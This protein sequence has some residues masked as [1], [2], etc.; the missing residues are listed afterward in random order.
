MTYTT[1]ISID[2]AAGGAL[3]HKRI[4]EAYDLL[5]NMALNHYQWSN[6]RGGT[7]KKFLGKYEMDALD[8][9]AAKADSLLQKFDR[10]N[11]NAVGI[12]NMSCEICGRPSHAATKS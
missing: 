7:Q 9:I 6:V 12:S 11:M 5:E 10:I 1:G 3:M 4:D 2:T 8:I